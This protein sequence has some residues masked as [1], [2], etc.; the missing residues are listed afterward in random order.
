MRG[1]MWKIWDRLV[2]S[3]LGPTTQ[4]CDLLFK[5]C[6]G[7]LMRHAAAGR[8]G[9]EASSQTVRMQS[10]S[11]GISKTV[12]RLLKLWPKQLLDRSRYLC[13]SAYQPQLRK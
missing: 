7:K 4:P 11:C 2:T 12:W 3:C 13:P 1:T 5:A 10:S 6:S 8:R 9:R